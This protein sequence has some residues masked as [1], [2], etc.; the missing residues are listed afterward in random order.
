MGTDCR[1][2]VLQLNTAYFP[3]LKLEMH[4]FDK[5]QPQCSCNIVLTKMYIK[6]STRQARNEGV[7]PVASRYS[8]ELAQKSLFRSEVNPSSRVDYIKFI[9][10]HT[11]FC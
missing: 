10:K 4:I 1:I 7:A 5:F 3:T 8:Y 11:S 2:T 9:T 6:E